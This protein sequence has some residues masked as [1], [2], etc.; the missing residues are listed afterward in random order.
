MGETTGERFTLAGDTIVFPANR[1]GDEKETQPVSLTAG[2]KPNPKKLNSG[3]T[4]YV[5]RDIRL[6]EELLDVRGFV[7][8]RTGTVDGGQ[9][10]MP[11]LD[12]GI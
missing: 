1:G 12:T 10:T 4:V 11:I 6:D 2:V 5:Q 7:I 3:L 8:I 9:F